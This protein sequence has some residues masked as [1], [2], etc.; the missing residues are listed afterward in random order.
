[1]FGETGIYVPG[2]W[3]LIFGS[4][5][6]APLFPLTRELW[7]WISSMVPNVGSQGHPLPLEEILGLVSGTIRWML[8]SSSW[9]SALGSL[10]WLMVHVTITIVRWC[11][12]LLDAL[13][14]CFQNVP[15]KEFN[16]FVCFGSLIVSDCSICFLFRPLKSLFDNLLAIYFF[17]DTPP[18]M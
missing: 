9:G 7:F 1:M 16:L 17:L 13:L 3:S 10:V 14:V 5:I 18:C 6:N 11:R 8:V 2:P 12:I 4:R 15:L